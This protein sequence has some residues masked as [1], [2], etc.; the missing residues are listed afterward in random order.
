MRPPLNDKDVGSN[1][2]VTIFSSQGPV[3]PLVPPASR[4]D[5]RGAWFARMAVTRNE[6]TDI[7]GPPP[8]KSGPIVWT[9]PQW[10][11]GDVKPN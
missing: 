2:A 4:S 11:T 10:K 3:S 8:Q 1:P 6:K 7:G 5:G 9:G